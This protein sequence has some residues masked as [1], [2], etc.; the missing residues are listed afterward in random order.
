MT[1]WT[2]LKNTL[3]SIPS[4]RSS[5]PLLIIESD[6]WGS[7]RMR[8]HKA[9]GELKQLGHQ[10]DQNFYH[11][12][13]GLETGEDVSLLARTLQEHND[14]GGQKACM[15]LNYL[16]A[17]PDFERIEKSKF[18]V[19]YRK[20][21]SETYKEY[22]GNADTISTVKLGE[23]NRL[24]DI[25]FHGTEHLQVP[26]WMK[27][28]NNQAKLVREAFEQKVFSPAVADTMGYPMEF[29]D[30][31]DYDSVDE[32]H[33]QIESLQRGLDIFKQTWGKLPVS[34]IAPCYRW[35]KPVESFLA[36][37]DIKYIQGQR[38]QLHPKN[39]PGYRQ[40]KI[41]R[42]TGHTN[43]YGQIYT[44]RNVIFEPSVHGPEKA[45]TMAKDQ[46][47]FAFKLKVPAI[48]SSHRINYTS[49]LNKTNRDQS[50]KALRELLTWVSV[51]YPKVEFLSSSELGKRIQN[52]QG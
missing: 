52:T 20:T 16:S 7:I 2:S 34:F 40:R 9:Y 28:L 47:A 23:V 35:S 45:L 8:S 10:V 33:S 32:V 37:Q 24:F 39:E 46:I 22:D 3:F 48:V 14:I 42:Y 29:M 21:I 50:L 13:D 25:Q 1:S 41:Y 30:A 11:Q 19:Y 27:G 43:K 36:T 6:D 49:R 38:A 15:T 31:L 18:S 4:W 17:N 5:H 51:N 26:R 44:V 12:L